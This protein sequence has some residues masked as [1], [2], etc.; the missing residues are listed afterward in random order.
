MDFDHLFPDVREQ[1]ET[2]L[3]QCQ[4][5]MLRMLKIL[6]Y[7]CEKHGIHY[8]LVGGS[9]LGAVRHKG[10]IPWD[11]DLDVGMTRSE[12][13]KFVR[14][15]VPELPYDIF[16]QTPETDVYYPACSR[17][18]ARLKDK[19]SSYIQSGAKKDQ[20]H[21]LGLQLD[22]F[23]YDRAYLPHNAFIFALNRSLQ[24]FFWKVGANSKGNINRAKLLMA[25]SKN[26]PI[27]LV[28]ASSFIGYDK[29]IK[30]GANYIRKNKIATLEK[31]PFEVMEIYIPQ[32]W[33]ACLKR[34]YG[35][36]MKLPPVEKQVGLH[37]ANP[38]DPF[39]PSITA[40]SCTGRIERELWPIEKLRTLVYTKKGRACKNMERHAHGT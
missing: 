18:E 25:I 39:H 6:H 17:V 33:D 2:R 11:D 37:N 14:Y 34:Q 16:F 12:Y 24:V 38:P 4:M 35:D 28:Y 10:F 22:I 8:F 32:G 27:P 23:V 9:L 21:H 7:L 26:T 40:K 19:Y 30:L 15:A 20:K 3:R 36:Y 13:E 1:G 5:V 29:M 31:V